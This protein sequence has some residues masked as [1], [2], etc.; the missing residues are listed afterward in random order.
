M[1][2][3]ETEQTPALALYTEWMDETGAGEEKIT[4]LGVQAFSAGLLFATA[5]DSL[6]SDITRESLVTALEG[7][8]EWDGGGLHMPTNPGE[9]VHNDCFL[10]MHIEDGDYY[11]S[12]LEE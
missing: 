3:S 12:W 9:A 7:I 8:T 2:F 5:V 4:S 10:Y 6:G 11:R 1:P